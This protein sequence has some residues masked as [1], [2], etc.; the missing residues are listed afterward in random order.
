ML[1][2]THFYFSYSYTKNS[3]FIPGI[4]VIPGIIYFSFQEPAPGLYVVLDE[5]KFNKGFGKR[6]RV[7]SVTK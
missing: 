2:G 3:R 5:C 7:T 6:L 1:P 4:T